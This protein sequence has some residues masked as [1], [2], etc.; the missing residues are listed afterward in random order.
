MAKMIL[1][2]YT[3]QQLRICKLV[4]FISGKFTENAIEK[5]CSK[6]ESHSLR[7]NLVFIDGDKIETLAERFRGIGKG[8]QR[9]APDET[10]LG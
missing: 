5:I 3:R 1:Y 6:I 4:I 8:E 9:L 10:T 2:I 7:N